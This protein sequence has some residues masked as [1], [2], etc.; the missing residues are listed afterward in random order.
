M[1]SLFVGNEPIEMDRRYNVAFV[2][3]QGVPHSYGKDRK[4]LEIHAVSGLKEYVKKNR[5]IEASLRGTVTLI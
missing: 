3:M 4:N 5:T 1:Q 2:T